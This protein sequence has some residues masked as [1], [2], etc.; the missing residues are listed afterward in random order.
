MKYWKIVFRP[1]PATAMAIYPFMLFKSR[2]QIDNPLLINHEMIHFRQQLEL[3]ILPFYLLYLIFYLINLAKSGNHDQAYRQ[4]CFEQEAYANEQNFNY[5]KV[6]KSYA[7]LKFLFN[8][9][10]Q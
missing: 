9:R 1:L 8:S 4:S 3:L 5:L 2:N 7:W 6:R 10:H